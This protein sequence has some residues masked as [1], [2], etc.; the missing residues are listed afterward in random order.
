MNTPDVPDIL[1]K[2]VEVKKNETQV[3]TSKIQD[4]KAMA[5][6]LPNPLDFSAALSVP[7]LSVIAEI[8]KASPSAGIIAEAFEPEKIAKAYRGAG[9]DAVSVL[10]DVEFFK[11]S[12]EYIP[13]VRPHLDGIP[14]LRKDFI[15]DSSQIYEAR[16]LGA[17]TFLLISAILTVDEMKEFIFLGRSLGMEPLVESH[18]LQELE[19]ALEADAKILGVNNR[20][21][22]DFTVDIAMSEKLLPYMPEGTVKVSESGI[23]TPA[24]AQRMSAAGFDAIL[25]GESLMREGP[26]KCKDR[27]AEFKGG[28]N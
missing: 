8:K 14:V 11:G 28:G 26:D 1:K 25:A 23:K 6:D 7:G 27:I 3:L 17:D 12:P 15:I 10:T 21:L 2:I 18:T 22:H 4:F 16:S 24:D 19:N 9:A 20:N 5:K 13:L